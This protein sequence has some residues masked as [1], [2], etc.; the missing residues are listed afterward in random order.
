MPWGVP[1]PLKKELFRRWAS[2]HSHW[3]SQAWRE[4]IS[5][6]A[7]WNLSHREDLVHGTWIVRFKKNHIFEALHFAF[8]E[9][10]S[11][12]IYVAWLWNQ[13]EKCPIFPEGSCH[14]HFF[15]TVSDL[16]VHVNRCLL[17]Y[18]RN[19]IPGLECGFIMRMFSTHVAK[20]PAP[21]ILRKQFPR[22]FIFSESTLLCSAQ[23]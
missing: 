20:Y 9:M 14:F 3:T 19:D 7:G 11:G 12:R 16:E 1:Q 4:T 17:N 5:V 10:N 18:F 15:Y 2:W 22:L 21:D 13:A 8:S 6:P 23:H